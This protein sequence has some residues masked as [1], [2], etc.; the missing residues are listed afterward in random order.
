MLTIGIKAADLTVVKTD[1]TLRPN[2][3]KLIIGILLIDYE[4]FK[5]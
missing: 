1:E 5:L 4:A 3:S 2:I